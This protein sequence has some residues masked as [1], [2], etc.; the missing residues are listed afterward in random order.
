MQFIRLM[1]FILTLLTTIA[2]PIM[3]QADDQSQE[4]TQEQADAKSQDE[5]VEEEEAE[6]D[7]EAM[8]EP[9]DEA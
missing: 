9:P 4:S 3:L 6:E 5:L 7:N 8:D 1:Q 2:S